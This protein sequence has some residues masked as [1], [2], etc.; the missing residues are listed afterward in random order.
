MIVLLSFAGVGIFWRVEDDR[1]DSGELWASLLAAKRFEGAFI[2]E[3]PNAYKGYTV[4]M[5]NEFNDIGPG[6]E[7]LQVGLAFDDKGNVII[8][9]SNRIGDKMD[10]SRK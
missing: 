9:L 7:M 10:D 8:R 6:V 2:N 1:T 5:T 4:I 3:E